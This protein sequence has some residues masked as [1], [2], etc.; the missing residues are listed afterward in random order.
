MSVRPHP[1]A[2]TKQWAVGAIGY[3]CVLAGIAWTS[4]P[5]WATALCVIAL[6]VALGFWLRS[7][8][9]AVFVLVIPLWDAVRGTASGDLGPDWVLDLLLL[10][11]VGAVLVSAGAFLG[12]RRTRVLPTG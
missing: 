1:R 7:Y 11:P 12:R 8:A 3:G 2:S 6:W 10:V 4:L 5:G 9:A